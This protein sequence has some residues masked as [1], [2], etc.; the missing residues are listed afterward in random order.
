MLMNSNE[1]LLKINHVLQDSGIIDD[2]TDFF[3]EHSEYFTKC[4]DNKKIISSLNIDIAM[5]CKPDE[6][7]NTG[8]FILV[9]IGDYSTTQVFLN[10]H[11]RSIGASVE[12]KRTINNK[13]VSRYVCN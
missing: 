9:N 13:E 1:L 11:S 7:Q 6:R 8:V 12:L 2:V 4:S 3:H 10:D 5:C